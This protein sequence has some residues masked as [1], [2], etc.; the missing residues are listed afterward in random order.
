ML[1]RRI[2]A[3]AK[4]VLVVVTNVKPPL[5]EAIV[6]GY[7]S[8]LLF[9][10]AFW[11]IDHYAK[12]AALTHENWALG[13]ALLGLAGGGFSLLLAR[14]RC[15]EL[16]QHYLNAEDQSSIWFEKYRTMHAYAKGLQRELRDLRSHALQ[17]EQEVN[18]TATEDQV[19]YPTVDIDTLS[20]VRSILQE[21][22]E[23][24]SRGNGSLLVGRG[25]INEAIALLDVA[26][27]GAG[28]QVAL[29]PVD[30]LPT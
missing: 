7:A 30:E 8:G 19:T 21:W 3:V 14:V 5:L 9:W 25:P 18:R 15:R 26:I 1:R 23:E 16:H 12:S 22:D 27:D 24:A 6:G 10:L 29:A 28:Q 2:Q 17:L 13:V 20:E 11:A 4:R